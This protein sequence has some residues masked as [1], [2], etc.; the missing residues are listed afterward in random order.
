MAQ[1]KNKINVVAFAKN[2]TE[3]RN[4]IRFV[5]SNMYKN[6]ITTEYK[7]YKMLASKITYISNQYCG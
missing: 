5:S 7:Y 4:Y 6:T 3:Y 1:S 2:K